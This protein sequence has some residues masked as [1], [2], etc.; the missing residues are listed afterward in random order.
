[1]SFHPVLPSGRFVNVLVYYGLSLGVSRVGTDIYLTQFAFGLIEIP[2]RALV[3]L[4]LPW[5]RRL[6][7]SGFLAFGGVASLLMLAVPTGK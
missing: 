5:S 4:V 6:A 3:L 1:M 2:A 7:Q